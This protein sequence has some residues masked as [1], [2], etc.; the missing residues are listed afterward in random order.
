MG[1][2]PRWGGEYERAEG[3]VC[4]ACD[5]PAT[6]TVTVEYGYM[7]GTDHEP[8]AVCPRHRIVAKNQI[9]RFIA[10]MVTKE[11]FLAERKAREAS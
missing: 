10:H 4:E 7:R 8:H 5:K 6:H 9:R 11:R 3:D 1:K 2:Y